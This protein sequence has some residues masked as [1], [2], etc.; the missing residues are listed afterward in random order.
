MQY[1]QYQTVIGQL[2]TVYNFSCPAIS[3]GTILGYK[4][5]PL[6]TFLCLSLKT[7]I[8]EIFK[9]LAVCQFFVLPLTQFVCILFFL[10]RN[11]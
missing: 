10:I 3:G 4:L 2:Q 8:K 6:A 5:C 9:Y 1:R 7:E 11:C